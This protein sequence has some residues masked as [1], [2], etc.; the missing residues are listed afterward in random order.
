MTRSG[1][2]MAAR[3]VGDDLGA[4]GVPDVDQHQQLGVGVQLQE[5]G[6]LV[7]ESHAPDPSAACR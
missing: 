5:R 6:G 7:R 4:H 2:S 1:Q 3:R